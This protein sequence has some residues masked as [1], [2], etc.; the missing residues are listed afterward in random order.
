[1]I[2]VREI[3]NP[4]NGRL[5]YSESEYSFRYEPRDRSDLAARI[6][7]DGVTSLSIGTLQVEVGVA[8]RQLL[9]V[10]GLHPKLRWLQG[11]FVPPIAEPGRLIAELHRNLEAGVSISLAPVNSWTTHFDPE[12]GWVRVA[13]DE[14]SEDELTQIADGVIVGRALDEFNSLWLKPIFST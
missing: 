4:L 12:S 9:F 8:T 5:V 6:G 10:W 1:M 13:K 3:G 14:A 2:L 7:Q 11:S